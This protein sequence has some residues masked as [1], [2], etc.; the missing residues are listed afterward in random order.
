MGKQTANTENTPFTG[1][2]ILA[3]DSGAAADDSS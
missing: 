2:A 1:A 3:I